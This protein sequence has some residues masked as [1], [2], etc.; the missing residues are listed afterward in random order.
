MEGLNGFLEIINSQ[1]NNNEVVGYNEYWFI[2]NIICGDD[3]TFIKNSNITNN[4]ASNTVLTDIKI[5][6][7]SLIKNNKAEQITCNWAGGTITHST[8]QNNTAS[9]TIIC[10]RCGQGSGLS[11][12]TYCNFIGNKGYLVT[13]KGYSTEL[14]IENNYWGSSNPNWSK[15]LKNIKKPTKYYKYKI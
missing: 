5:L 3:L 4:H 14:T 7:N 10:S 1:I 6:N 8:F 15:I 12:L 13:E 9:E 11:K 2:G